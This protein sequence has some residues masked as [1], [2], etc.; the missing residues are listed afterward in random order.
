ME[1]SRA[2]AA[3]IVRHLPELSARG[4]GGRPRFAV[5]DRTIVQWETALRAETIDRIRCPEHYQRGCSDLFISA[6]ID[7]VRYERTVPLTRAARAALDR[8]APLRGLI[9]GRHSY[10]DYLKRAA[11]AAAALGLIDPLKAPNVSI[12]DFRH[13][14]TTALCESTR[15][16]VGISFLVGHRQ[17]TTTNRYVHA[18]HRAATSALLDSARSIVAEEEAAKPLPAPPE[19]GR[20]DEDTG[21]PPEAPR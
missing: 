8:R 11:T 17:M 9:F 4:R 16:L 18:S 7:K 3:A 21:E 5:R 2:E 12:K 15:N 10:A 1:L 6:D 19:S 14:A 13:G 20:D